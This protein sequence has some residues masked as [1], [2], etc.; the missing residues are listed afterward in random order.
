MIP[1]ALRRYRHLGV[2]VARFA[3]VGVGATLTH[4]LIVLMLVE[5]GLLHPFWA[6]LIAFSTALFV[7]YFGNHQWVFELRGEHEHYFPKFIVIAL[8]GLALNQGI[9][10]LVVDSLGWDY[11]ISLFLVVTAVPALTF[12]LNR[13]WAFRRSGGDKISALDN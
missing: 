13:F 3:I 10:Y 5:N 11:R 6:N 8:L 12:A 2:Q 4:V 1:A 7:T 9:V